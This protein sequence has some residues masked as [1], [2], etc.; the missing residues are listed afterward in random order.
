MFGTTTANALASLIAGY[1]MEISKRKGILNSGLVPGS[2]A[3][4]SIER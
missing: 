4:F 3:E 1:F 2:T